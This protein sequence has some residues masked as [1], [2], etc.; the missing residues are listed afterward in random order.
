MGGLFGDDDEY[1]AECDGGGGGTVTTAKNV[2]VKKEQVRKTRMVPK[3]VEP[4]VE[5]EIE[6]QEL[7]TDALSIIAQLH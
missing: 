1:G 6:K 4:K 5:Q 2:E 7:L 3:R